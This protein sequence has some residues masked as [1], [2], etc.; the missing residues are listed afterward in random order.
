MNIIQDN[1][2]FKGLI[3]PD[4][5]TT[6]GEYTF[7]WCANLSS[8]S[9]PE[10][11]TS[12][13]I[14][15]SWHCDGFTDVTIPGALVYDFFLGHDRGDV[16]LNVVLT[17]AGS[18]PVNAFFHCNNELTSVTIGDGITGIGNLAFRGCTNLATVTIGAA[19][20]SSIDGEDF[21]Y[22]ANLAAINVSE[23]NSVYSSVDGILFNRDKT[24][25]LCCPQKNNIGNSSR[26][27]SPLSKLRLFAKAKDSPV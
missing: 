17:G 6:I 24:S 21:D 13:P 23:E 5:L 3:L 22:C 20:A 19:V 8:I 9:I 12:M 25:L 15:A 7:C 10:S 11:V 4:S 2:F 26:P 16:G 27:L 14:N 1:Q 18:I